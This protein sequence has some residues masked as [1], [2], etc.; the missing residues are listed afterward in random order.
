[1]LGMAVF[2]SRQR[3][4]LA[5]TLDELQVSILVPGPPCHCGYSI[6]RVRMK[7]ENERLADTTLLWAGRDPVCVPCRVGE[8]FGCWGDQPKVGISESWCSPP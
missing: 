6:S 2:L 3:R 7:G 8:E 4:A 1:M 5:C